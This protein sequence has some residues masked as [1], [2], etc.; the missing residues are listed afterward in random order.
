M[1]LL[2]KVIEKLYEV[3]RNE[4]IKKI[5]EIIKMSYCPEETGVL[6]YDHA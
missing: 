4:V 3:I 6:S 1:K 2:K 5:I